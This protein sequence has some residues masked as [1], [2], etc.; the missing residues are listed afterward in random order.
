MGQKMNID[1]KKKSH[2]EKYAFMK[3]VTKIIF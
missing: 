2:I 1:K 3:E